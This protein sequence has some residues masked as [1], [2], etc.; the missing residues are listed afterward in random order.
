MMGV[1]GTINTKVR[2]GFG[3]WVIGMMSLKKCLIPT[4]TYTVMKVSIR[5]K[6][7]NMNLLI[8]C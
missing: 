1:I 7:K 5:H 3:Q 6:K 2:N 4:T 8:W